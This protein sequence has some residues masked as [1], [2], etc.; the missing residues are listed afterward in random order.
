LEYWWTCLLLPIFFIIILEKLHTY[1]FR[2]EALNAIC[3]VADVTV[4]TRTSEDELAM[5]Y[6]INS[7]GNIVTTKPSHFGKGKKRLTGRFIWKY[8]SQCVK[9]L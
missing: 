2:G 3:H 8:I 9:L 5:V 4:T 6:T 1:G 7:D